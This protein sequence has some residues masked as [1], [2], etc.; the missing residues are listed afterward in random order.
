MNITQ[1]LLI[2]VPSLLVEVTAT[3][4]NQ[5]FQ[6]KEKVAF[7]YFWF[8]SSFNFPY[9]FNDKFS[10]VEAPCVFFSSMSQLAG[11]IYPENSS[12]CN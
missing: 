5:N 7:D 9:N 2:D 4:V 1:T 12:E 6:K 3:L 11:G 10:K 8:L